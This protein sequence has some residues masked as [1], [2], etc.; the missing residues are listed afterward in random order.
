[1]AA[2][3]IDQI[4]TRELQNIIKSKEKIINLLLED[5]REQDKHIKV[6][7]EENY[8]LKSEINECCCYETGNENPNLNISKNSVSFSNSNRFSVLAEDSVNMTSNSPI[9]NRNFVSTG[10]SK[11]KCTDDSKTQQKNNIDPNHKVI[12][13]KDLEV[14]KTSLKSK[15]FKKPSISVYSDSQGRNLVNLLR[16][17][18]NIDCVGY[19]FPNAR[20]RDVIKNIS[21]Y[22]AESEVT[23]IFGGT[24]D[25]AFNESEKII[26][27]LEYMLPKLKNKVIVVDVPFRHDL[28]QWS[29]VNK[30]IVLINDRIDKLCEKFENVT[31]VKSSLLKRTQHTTHGLHVNKSG[32][33]HLAKMIASIVIEKEP[34]PP[35]PLNVPTG[36]LIILDDDASNCSLNSSLGS[37]FRGFSPIPEKPGFLGNRIGRQ[38]LTHMLPNYIPSINQSAF[39]VQ[40]NSKTL[41]L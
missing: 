5:I 30:E 27:E 21:T 38:D 10:R 36:E 25:V 15:G 11:K 35:T 33:C 23:A 31:M 40:E 12:Q 32:K 18:H 22:E 7:K 17:R 3:N 13:I 14:N 34:T 41:I 20:I 39:L 19:V 4:S 9:E 28:P 24:N 37:S 6:L 8:K 26:E 1:M 16:E 2:F 29:C